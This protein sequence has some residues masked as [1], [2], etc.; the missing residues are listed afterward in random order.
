MKF[1]ITGNMRVLCQ[2][3]QEMS[4]VQCVL[5]FNWRWTLI[6]TRRETFA[7]NRLHE[8]EMGE[9]FF[10]KIINLRIVEDKTC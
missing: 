6:N 2:T 4:A 5:I 3:T 10:K 8:C 1:S 9:Y 7:A